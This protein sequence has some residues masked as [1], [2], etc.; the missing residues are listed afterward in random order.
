MK[1]EDT[2]SATK[3]SAVPP[4]PMVILFRVA[5]VGIM[6]SPRCTARDVSFVLVA[7]NMMRCGK[8]GFDADQNAD[9]LETDRRDRGDDRLRPRSQSRDVGDCAQCCIRCTTK[10]M[11]T[12]T[13]PNPAIFSTAFSRTAASSPHTDCNASASATGTTSGSQ[14]VRMPSARRKIPALARTS[15]NGANVS[16]FE[17]TMTTPSALECL[18]IGDDVDDLIPLKPELRHGRMARNDALGERPFQAFNRILQVQRAERRR[19]RE[20][21]VTDLIDRMALL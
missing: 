21:T 1:M 13:A 3:A 14:V 15:N 4:S 2:A 19:D 18:Q 17:S 12:R 8:V 6:S 7:K 10:A 16:R 9:H 5:V 11:S 20:R